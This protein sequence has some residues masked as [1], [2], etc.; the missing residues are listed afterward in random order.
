MNKKIIA[1]ML[2]SVFFISFASA[3]LFDFL[4]S[5]SKETIIKIPSWQ[6]MKITNDFNIKKNELTTTGICLKNGVKIVKDK[7]CL[8]NN[9]KF[10]FINLSDTDMFYKNSQGITRFTNE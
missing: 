7:K 6:T 9:P 10:T 4:K 2:I 8:K 5:D 1:L 3:G